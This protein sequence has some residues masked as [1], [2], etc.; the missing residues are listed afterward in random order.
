MNKQTIY[1]IIFCLILAGGFGYFYYKYDFKK[2]TLEFSTISI[3]AEYNN[4]KVVTGYVIKTSNG[5]KIANTSQSYEKAMVVKNTIIKIYNKNIEDQNFYTDLREFNITEDTKR[6]NLKLVE[7]K[8]IKIK[9]LSTKPLLVNLE[10]EDARDI[11]FCISWSS[12][13]IFVEI[14]NFTKTENFE[15]WHKC[16]N[17]DFSLINSNKTIEIDYSKFG[18]PGKNDY[19]KLLLLN[20]AIESKNPQTIKIL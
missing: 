5:T 10:S 14:I 3:S 8:E 1:L 19:I 9:I 6:I 17:G 18:T 7:P 20:G 4:Q 15:N 11:D 16:Y 13:Y 12:N 2:P